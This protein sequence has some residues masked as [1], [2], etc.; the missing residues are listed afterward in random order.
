MAFLVRRHPLVNVKPREAKNVHFCVVMRTLSCPGGP[1]REAGVV[2]VTSVMGVSCYYYNSRS[3]N[4][5]RRR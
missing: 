4:Y 3:L 2:V 1:T 5:R